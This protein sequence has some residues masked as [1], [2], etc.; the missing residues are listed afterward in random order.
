MTDTKL[1]L[2]PN[3][4]F[5]N[6]RTLSCLDLRNNALEEISITVFDVPTLK[7]IYLAGNNNPI[8]FFEEATNLSNKQVM[9]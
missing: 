7:D 8:K 3:D 5:S 2:L 9:I 4:A 6:L 1:R